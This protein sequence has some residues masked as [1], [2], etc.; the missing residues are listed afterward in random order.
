MK[1]V[2]SKRILPHNF[3]RMAG[4]DLDEDWLSS[5]PTAMLEPVII[6]ST[7]GLQMVLPSNDLTVSKVADIVGTETPVEVIGALLL[8]AGKMMTQAIGQTSRHSQISRI[9][10]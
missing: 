3:R 5:D 4:H 8:C 10:H 9:G 6:E 7:E 1:V 2:R